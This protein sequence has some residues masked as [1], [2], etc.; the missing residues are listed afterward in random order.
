MERYLSPVSGSNATIVLPLFSGRLASSIAAQRAA[1]DEMPTSTPSLL[2]KSLPVAN[3]SSLVTGITSSYTAVLRTSGTK[4]A[5]IPWILCAPAV[6]L[7]RTGESAGSTATTFT[8]AFCD[9]KN[10]PTPVTVPPVPTPA[11]KISTSP[12]VS[13]QISGPVVSL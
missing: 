13:S 8:D 3:A 6:P 9:F 4:P 7:L 11:T 10:S 12:S 5:P 1:P 2:P